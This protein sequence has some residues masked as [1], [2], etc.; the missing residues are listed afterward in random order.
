MLIRLTREGEAQAA[1]SPASRLGGKFDEYRKAIEGARFDFARKV[2][3]ASL[4]K[5]PSIL[6]RLRD[7]GFSVDCDKELVDALKRFT[8][9]QWL[10]LQSAKDR[11]VRVDEELRKLG[12]SRGVKLAL[13]GYQRVGVQWLST[14]SGAL[15]ADDMGLGKS[16]QVITSIPANAPV[17]VVAPAVAKGV[18][19]SEVAKWRPYLR[20]TILSGRGSFRWPEPGEVVIVN[21]DILPKPHEE[22]CKQEDCQGCASFLKDVPQG[23][24][25]VADE[26]H[27]LKSSKAIRTRSFRAIAEAGRKNHGRT[28][29]V[30]ATPLLN[31]PP[32]LWAILQSAGC[33]QEAFGSWNEFL[34]VFRARKKNFGGYDWGE[35]LPEVEERLK[36]VMLKRNKLDVATDMPSKSYKLV[37]VTIDKKTIALCDQ[38]LEVMK[39]EEL[40]EAL[41]HEKKIPFEKMS[42]VR[43][44]LA[45]AKIPALLDIVDEYEQAEEPL[46]VFSAHRGPVDTIGKREGWK[47]ITGDTSSSERTEI[48]EAFQ[49]G[50]LKGVACTIDAGGVAITLTRASNAV[51]CDL[52]WTPGLNSQAEDRIHRL[53]QDKPVLITVLVAN[54]ALDAR[55][56]KLLTQ[57]QALINASVEVAR[58]LPGEDRTMI[59]A[60]VIEEKIQAATEAVTRAET[61]DLPPPPVKSRFR[62]PET[63]KEIWAANA[64]RQ[65]DDLNPDGASEVN[66]VGFNKIDGPFGRSVRRQLEDRGA[67][68]EP[69]WKMLFQI[70]TKYWRQVGRCP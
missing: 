44:A 27:A 12:E 4:D 13:R 3:I 38:V 1:I 16:I 10:D 9:Q 60:K 34:R 45:V 59:E 25:T 18:W 26:A 69:Q 14:R 46:V 55:V 62:P 68:S 31:R 54:H 35:P 23:L 36:R 42:E 47:T 50:K 66:G 5:V 48:V 30:T 63:D 32:E 37:D 49:A 43:A 21:Y 58:D 61:P 64:L 56:S 52:K 65:L 15:L 57:K 7:K 6:Q 2:N 53:G 24:V 67:L 20:T 22:G 40:E 28:W 41:S 17:L 11:L 39:L 70:L 51:F 29:L 33:A 8:A 19:Q